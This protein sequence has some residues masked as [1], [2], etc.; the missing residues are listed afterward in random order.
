MA[1]PGPP[2][3]YRLRRAQRLRGRRTFDRVFHARCRKNAGP[4][5]VNGRPNGLAFTRIGVVA[6]RR[7]GNA[8][9]RNRL[10]RLLRE[11]FRL[12]QHELPAGYDIVVVLK[13]HQTLS[14]EQYKHLLAQAL[15][16]IDR[17][18]NRRCRAK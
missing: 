8:V 5:A 9:K 4:L 11:A 13:P 10:K 1:E 6:P 14:L 17:E 16:A 3:R 7:V 12:T 18:W 15:N 2:S